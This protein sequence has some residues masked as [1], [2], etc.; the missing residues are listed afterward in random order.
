PRGRDRGGGAAQA[1]RRR[2]RGG[3]VLLAGV[4]QRRICGAPRGVRRAIPAVRG[5]RRCRPCRPQRRSGSCGRGSD[6]VVV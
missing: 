5:G 2:L 6:S 3:G 4:R 1:V